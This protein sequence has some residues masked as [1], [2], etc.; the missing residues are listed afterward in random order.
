MIEFESFLKL[1]H[2]VHTGSQNHRNVIEMDG[3]RNGLTPRF[4]PIL[5][6]A[7]GKGG[8]IPESRA[9]PAVF[10]VIN[11]YFTPPRER[12]DVSP[13]PSRVGFHREQLTQDA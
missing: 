6:G 11:L 3:F 9:L 1:L 5:A 4:H 8:L 12:F 13:Q 2:S 10:P 7:P